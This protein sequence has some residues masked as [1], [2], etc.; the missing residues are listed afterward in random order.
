MDFR[1][2]LFFLG[3]PDGEYSPPFVATLVTA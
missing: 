3:Y 1:D 2:T